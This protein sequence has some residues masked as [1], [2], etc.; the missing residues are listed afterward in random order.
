MITKFYKYPYLNSNPTTLEV[1]LESFQ[2]THVKSFKEVVLSNYQSKIFDFGETFDKF[3][4]S[5]VILDF[6]E[7]IEEFIETLKISLNQIEIELNPSELIFGAGLDYTNSIFC[8]VLNNTISY[9]Q[10]D[11]GFASLTL[12]LEALTSNG[13]QLSFK[14]SI[15]PFFPTNLA[16]QF[17][18]ERNLD[19][20]GKPF[21]SLEHGVQGNSFSFYATT[22]APFL[23]TALSKGYFDLN[24][25]C[26]EATAGS[27][28][29]QISIQRF[30]PLVLPFENL[31]YLF[32]NQ[33]TSEVIILNLN[34]SRLSFNKWSITISLVNNV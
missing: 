31:P 15:N 11:N 3:R 9:P 25:I 30:E 29:K 4:T 2:A 28:E 23:R 27:F 7:K 17:E 21:S 18:L 26:D 13:L 5:I 8:N 16:F 32:E 1:C 6:K 12:D 22:V 20:D 14:E 24:F 19:R 34:S 33:E 10:I